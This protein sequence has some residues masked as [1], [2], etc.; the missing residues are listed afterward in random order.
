MRIIAQWRQEDYENG[1]KEGISLEK[2]NTAKNMLLNKY[3]IEEIMEIT[4]LN[5]ETI[6]NLK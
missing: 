1:K 6:L 2:I 4:H 3:S 5:K